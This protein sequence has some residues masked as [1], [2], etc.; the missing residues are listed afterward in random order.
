MSGNLLLDWATLAISLFDTI[1]LLWMGLTVLLNAENRTAGLWIAGG[2]LSLGGIFFLSHSIILVN[3]LDRFSAG[4]NFWWHLGWFPVVILPLSWYGV[5]LWYSGYWN[6]RRAPLRKR[7]AAWLVIVAGFAALVLGMLFFANP[8]PSFFQISSFEITATPS[9]FGIPLLILVYPVY[10]VLCLS[11]SLDVLRRPNPSSRLMGELARQRAR[12]WLMGATIV[13]ILVSLLVGWVMLWVILNPGPGI[14]FVVAQFDLAISVLITLAVLL[15]GQAIVD[16]EVFTGKSL[17]RRGLTHY[18]RRLIFL[19]GG[20]AIL[21]SWSLVLSL[22][23]I[24]ILLISSVLMSIFYALL[25]WRSFADRETYIRQLRPFVTSHGLY[26]QLIAQPTTQLP[27][28]D[29]VGMFAAVCRDVLDARLAYLV[30]YGSTASLAGSPLSYPSGLAGAIPSAGDI[31]AS[32][33]DPHTLCIPYQAQPSQEITWVVPLWSAQGK[34]GALFLGKK[35]NEGIYAQ[36][37]IEIARLVCERLVDAQASAEIASRLMRLQRQR[38][39]ESQ[40]LDQQTRRALHDDILPQIHAVLLSLSGIPQGRLGEGWQDNGAETIDAA[41]ITLASLHRQIT[42]LLQELPRPVAPELA[43]FGLIGALRQ[44]V[45]VELKPAFDSISWQ[46]T[47]DIESALVV[48]P[49][50]VVEVVYYAAREAL[51]NAGKHARSKRSSSPLHLRVQAL[52]D[53]DLKLV[54]EDNGVGIEDANSAADGSGQ[55]LSLH[56]TMMAVLGGSLEVESRRG[57]YTRVILTL[58]DVHERVHLDG[59]SRSTPG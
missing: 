56:S 26:D 49:P 37:E 59:Q 48:L 14:M 15:V 16:Y 32:I 31:L 34:I 5:M 7:H 28:L 25:S 2:E 13:L 57:E 54:V 33:N 51:R 21:V 10:I 11:L 35:Q 4:L 1:I 20:Y 47:P 38:L 8:L 39:A 27:G 55:G 18:W 19:A 44:V 58:P 30:P 52:L 29:V 45:D 43:R 46:V 3:G 22:S 42:Q 36:E 9:L 12:P 24:Y 50:F 41:V 6:D 23:S 17:P 40:L 53:S